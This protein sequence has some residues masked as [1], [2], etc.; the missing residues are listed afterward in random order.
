MDYV[1]GLPEVQSGDVG[2]L[3]AV[4]AFSG[5]V[6]AQPVRV[7]TAGVSVQFLVNYVGLGDLPVNFKSQVELDCTP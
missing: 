5:Y 4:D 1:S 7:M 2:V 6:I 3:V